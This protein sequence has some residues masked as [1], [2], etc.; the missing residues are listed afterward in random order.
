ML[1]PWVLYRYLEKATNK[2]TEYNKRQRSANPPRPATCSTSPPPS[3]PPSS[4]TCGFARDGG[5]HKTPS[6]W[7]QTQFTLP[8]PVMFETL[9]LG[10]PKTARNDIPPEKKKKKKKKKK[11]AHTQCAFGNTRL[12][13]RVI[14]RKYTD[15][16]KTRL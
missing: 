14:Y 12:S 9:K 3:G 15:F 2:K 10:V 4:P 1:L 11:H 8:Q 5:N 6:H 7:K 13:D 16:Q